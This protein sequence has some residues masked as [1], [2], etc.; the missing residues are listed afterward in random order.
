M[1][2]DSMIERGTINFLCKHIS[3]VEDADIQ[4]ECILACIAIVLGGN[5]L[6]QET[7]FL[8]M[9]DEDAQE[10]KFMLTIKTIL[11]RNFELV[12]KFMIEKNAKLEMIFKMKQRQ[13]PSP[14]IKEEEKK[15]VKKGLLAKLFKKDKKDEETNSQQGD[16]KVHHHHNQAEEEGQEPDGDEEEDESLLMIK[17]EDESP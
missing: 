7:F 5:Q 15:P 13:K 1:K 16:A 9:R 14:A 8:F 12:K 17:L 11:M 3:E 2:Q 4:E 10:N 6:A